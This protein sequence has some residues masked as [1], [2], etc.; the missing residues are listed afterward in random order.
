MNKLLTTATAAALAAGI[1][2]TASART[3][4]MTANQSFGP[5]QS[6]DFTFD[7]VGANTTNK[8]LMACGASDGGST[9]SGWDSIRFVADVPGDVTTLTGV[10]LPA[11]LGAVTHLR[12]FL[13]SGGTVPDAVQLD[14]I[15]ATQTGG[16]QYILTSFTANGASKVEVDFKFATTTGTQNIFCSRAGANAGNYFVLFWYIGNNWWWHYN[17][18]KVSPSPAATMDT[19]RHTLRA[20]SSG[21]TVDG[22]LLEGTART[23]ADF[24]ANGPMSIFASHTGGNPVSGLGNYGKWKLY[25]FKAW[26][27]GSDDSTLALDLVPC[28]K[29]DGTVCLYNKVEGTFLTN[30]G[31]GAFTAGD[32][33]ETIAGVSA[34][35][36]FQAVAGGGTYTW[37]GGGADNN[38][39]TDGNWQGGH[40]PD[41]DAQAPSLVFASGA[42]A[43]LNRGISVSGITFDGVADFT[44]SSSGNYGIALGEGGISNA[45]AAAARAITVA[46]PVMPL[47]NQVWQME[48]N[49]AFTLSGILRKCGTPTLTVRQVTH[50]L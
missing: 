44:V 31:T 24:T 41:F 33:G 37:V 26:A 8:L 47:A 43:V 23:A 5:V 46:V 20:D 6:F 48:T 25:S 22:T 15:E 30:A 16:N 12:F 4:T 13:T 34:S 7:N 40:A 21:L 19:A 50:C 11:D 27:D 28:M 18:E 36:E 49:T 1:A 17:N 35:V 3:M 2:F 45:P 29:Y 14:G 38:I 39:T 32:V 42:A 9:F 10:T